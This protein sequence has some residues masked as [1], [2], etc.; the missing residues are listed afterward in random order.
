MNGYI[1]THHS[2]EQVAAREVKELM[3]KS[4]IVYPSVIEFPAS[5]EELITLL[6][7][8]QSARRLL[9]A[10]GKY[11]SLENINLYAV[12]FPFSDIF[13]SAKTFKVEVEGVRGQE[14][15]SA[16]AKELSHAFFSVLQT[17][18]VITPKIELRKP[19]IVVIVFW[20]GKEYFV[21][22]DLAGREINGREYRL[23]PHSASL[24]GDAAYV[25]VRKTE[26]APGQK[27]L[28]GFM[29]D[30]TLAIEAA[31]FAN[32]KKMFPTTAPFSFQQWRLFQGI[33]LEEC[34]VYLSEKTLVYG[35]DEALPNV[36][37]SR[38]NAALAGVKDLVDLQKMNLDEL[39]VHFGQ[40]EFD[41][42]IFMVTTKDEVKINEMYYQADYVL[43]SKGTFLIV[44]RSSWNLPISG[45]FKLLK[46]EVLERGESKH[47][48]WLLRKK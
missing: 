27:L 9:L 39:D 41:H 14:N 21:G 38:K 43:K 15:R 20:N 33:K 6:F 1:I 28:V 8:V 19:D 37:A 47:C 10:V 25:I 48:L 4:A 13:S 31:L 32:N 42:L 36:I 5:R 40:N 45:K 3:G 34:P 12:Y 24:K 16:I 2:L 44:T 22:M 7:R 18:Y 46:K 11:E 17:K 23:F 35:F 30:G 29:K 26:F